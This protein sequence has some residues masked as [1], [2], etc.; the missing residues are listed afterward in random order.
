MGMCGRD[1]GSRKEGERKK[2]NE[3]KL[4]KQ[5]EVTK[6]MDERELK[7]ETEKERGKMENQRVSGGG[8]GLTEQRVFFFW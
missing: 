4:V 6:V 3:M 8:N 5:R 1:N 2:C 7:G